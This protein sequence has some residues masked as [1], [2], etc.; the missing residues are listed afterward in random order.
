M[1][2]KANARFFLFWGSRESIWVIRANEATATKTQ[3]RRVTLLVLLN[4]SGLQ[5]V[6][7]RD[8]QNRR[9][10]G[11]Q[12]LLRLLVV[13]ALALKTHTDAARRVLHTELPDFLI[14]LR[15]QAHIVRAHCLLCELDHFLH[16]PRGALL[17][18]HAVHALVKMN[19]VLALVEL[20]SHCT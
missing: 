13:V 5:T 10:V 18:L 1:K 8:A 15:V 6:E 19:G 2:A 20:A 14:Q 7:V 16:T 12:L 4:D 3:I 11:V 9:R 17:E